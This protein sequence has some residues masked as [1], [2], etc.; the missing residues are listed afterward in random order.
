M[1]SNI[2]QRKLK[3][4]LIR[5]KFAS[6]IHCFIT[7]LLSLV[8]LPSMSFAGSEV[9]LSL[10]HVGHETTAM[11]K[12]AARFDTHLQTV[13]GGAMSV[14]MFPRGQLGDTPELWVQMK[15]GTLDM[16]TIDFGAVSMN[17]PAAR[18]IVTLVPFL[19]RDQDHVRKYFKSDVF[20]ELSA[21]ITE[22]TGIRFIE[23]VS[24]RAPR[25][26]STT[27]RPVKTIDDMKGLRVRVP[28]A[29]LFIDI[30]K[31]W[32]AVPVSISSTEMLS[33]LKSGIVDGEDNGATSL[34]EGQN[35]V[36]IKH[37]TTLDWHRG[38]VA[39]WISEVTWQRLSDQQKNWVKEAAELAGLESQKHYA[40]ELQTAFDRLE[41][42][43]ITIHEPVVE[44]FYPAREAIVAKH[45]GKL[46]PAGEVEK[47]MAIK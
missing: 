4:K 35:S 33:A 24:E 6:L 26:V 45:E 42:K 14:K 1:K 18:A 44:G 31:A 19:F 43:G 25:V 16:Q 15:A 10:S 32:G 27:K 9:T 28:G 46:W 5:I 22:D 12:G 13:S 37:F 30:F 8:F 41:E 40:S 38:A 17:K 29:P 36:V 3:C 23:V 34:A 2:S 47:I 11:H 39:L 21:A 20:E 7:A